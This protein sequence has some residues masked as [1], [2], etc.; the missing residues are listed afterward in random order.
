MDER[1]VG[2]DK[3]M[4][5]GKVIQQALADA[6]AGDL[7]ALAWLQVVAPDLVESLQLSPQQPHQTA[8]IKRKRGAVMKLTWES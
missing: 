2:S 5:Y 7:E 4:R 6:R 3:L 1:L 8:T